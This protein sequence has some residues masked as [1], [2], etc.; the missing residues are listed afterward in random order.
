[1]GDKVVELGLGGEPREW[2]VGCGP[3]GQG[4]DVCGLRGQVLGKVSA[5]VVG[6]DSKIGEGNRGLVWVKTQ[7]KVS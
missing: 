3:G 6:F 4:S 5:H 2:G 7:T 1:M